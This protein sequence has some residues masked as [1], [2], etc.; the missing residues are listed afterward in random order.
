MITRAR[1]HLRSQLVGYIAL[2]AF[3]IGGTAQ[4]IDGPL[5]GTNQVGSEDIINNEIKSADIADGRIFNLDLA[6]DIV[7]SG[8]IKEGTLTGIDFA[9]NSLTGSDIDEKTLFNDDSLTTDDVDESTLFNDDSLTS[10]DLFAFAA[11]TDEIATGA[12]GASEVQDDSLDAD[13]L[14][15]NS[16]GASE[17]REGVVRSSELA[18]VVV[19]RKA[20]TIENTFEV[21]SVACP[22]GYAP[23]NVGFAGE[24]GLRV[25]GTSPVLSN[26]EVSGFNVVFDNANGSETKA[27]EVVAV[28]LVA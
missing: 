7:Q 19:E 23:L 27:A 17:I 21:V 10:N 28:C 4:A 16:V 8:K 11:R 6:D 15:A 24:L 9:A 20:A 25:L 2:F 14:G 22:A 3:A 5:P 1:G 18:P 26:G 12:V 13:E